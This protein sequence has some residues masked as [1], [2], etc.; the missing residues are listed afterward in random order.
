MWLVNRLQTNILFVNVPL[1]LLSPEAFFSPKGTKYRLAAELRPDLLGS[2]Q[3]SP[4]PVAGFKGYGQG[5][6]GKERDCGDGWG[7]EKG[8]RREGDMRH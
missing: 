6:G 3:R 7:E 4:D 1:I 2:L 8:L 5:R